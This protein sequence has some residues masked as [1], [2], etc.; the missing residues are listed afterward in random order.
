MRILMIVF[1]VLWSVT[2][3][4]GQNAITDTG[5]KV[6]LY[7]DGTWVYADDTKSSSMVIETN[8]RTFS[9]PP[10]AT[11]LLKSTTNNAAVWID[12]DKW[13]FRKGDPDK[14]AEY[15]FQLKGKDLYGMAITEEIAM[16]MATLA[17]LA[18]V[19]ARQAAPDA[20]IAR[21]EYRTVNGKK[22]LY[23]EISGTIQGIRFTYIG[24]YHTDEAGATQLITYTATN[25]AQN[26]VP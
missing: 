7:E 17:D 2:V 26:I 8:P 24:H 5:D 25:L 12:T 6:I 20:R 15:D 9:K 1:A 14:S 4:A 10:Q 18:L 16:P 3:L 13:I 19:N 11:F 21:Q 23:M 22:V